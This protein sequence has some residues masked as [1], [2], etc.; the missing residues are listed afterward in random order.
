MITLKRKKKKV[1]AD[2][3]S[4]YED[5][6]EEEEKAIPSVKE[7]QCEDYFRKCQEEAEKNN[8]IRA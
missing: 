8:K 6:D 5:V 7:F 1:H 3:T 2:D 4:E